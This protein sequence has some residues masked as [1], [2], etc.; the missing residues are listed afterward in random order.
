MLIYDLWLKIICLYDL[1][2]TDCMESYLEMLNGDLVPGFL[3]DAVDVEDVLTLDVGELVQRPKDLLLEVLS[4]LHMLRLVSAPSGAVT[5]L[6]RITSDT[7]MR[8]SGYYAMNLNDY[9]TK[10]CV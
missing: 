3:V 5:L 9:G 2:L 6:L 1:N 4:A 10:L 8:V 7:R